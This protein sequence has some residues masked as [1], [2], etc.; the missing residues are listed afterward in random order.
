MG[1]VL[2]FSDHARASS[3]AASFVSLSEVTPAPLARLVER[4]AAHRAAGMLS[5]CHHLE[6]AADPAEMSD[7]SASLEGQRSITSRKDR[8]SV[9]RRNLG[10]IVL[11]RKDVLA[12]DRKKFLGHD[13]RMADSEKEAF[14]QQFI[15][16]VAAARVATGLKQWQ[17]ADAL[18][19]P[20]DHYKHWEKTRVMP[21]HL[22]GRFCV[23]CRV[24][25]NWLLTGSGQKPLKAPHLVEE[26]PEPARRPSGRGALR[27]P[28]FSA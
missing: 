26:E 1:I 28:D 20:Q 7:A 17:V 19:V 23:I 15:G 3:R 4:T 21:H 2:R 18:G 14:D 8:I 16:R 10:P 11:K 24:D 9:I 22:I 25:P 6:T 13:G 27:P 5:R 12:L